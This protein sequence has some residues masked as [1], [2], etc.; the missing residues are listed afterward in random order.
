[1][2]Q[3]I[4]S[5]GLGTFRVAPDVTT[6]SVKSALELGYRHIDTATH[7]D[8]EAAVGAGIRASGVARDEICLVT[9]VWFDCLRH[10]EVLA[11]LTQSHARLDVGTIDVALI[12]WPSPDGVPVRETIGA[13]QEAVERGLIRHYGVSNFTAPLLE[14][15]MSVPGGDAIVTNQIEV[16]PFFANRA[17]VEATHELGVKVTAYM[18]LAEG[19]VHDDPTIRRIADHHRV[20]PAQI[21]CAWLLARG[22]IVLTASRSRDH[23]RANLNALNVQLSE[24]E[25]AAIDALDCGA[26]N[27]N[28]PF[29]PWNW[30][31]V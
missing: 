4:P 12:H 22:I 9:K 15:A 14:E 27:A 21:A 11:S 24:A 3:V 6:A 31:R 28:P 8:N 17:D 1:M 2:K 5:L 13:L 30:A 25:L 7:Y 29:A 16:N 19:R 18:P 10:D 26:R 20:S 23:Q